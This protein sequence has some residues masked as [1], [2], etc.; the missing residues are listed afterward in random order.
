MKIL[1]INRHDNFPNCHAVICI[2]AGHLNYIEFILVHNI[3]VRVML[4][5]MSV[6]LHLKLFNS[7]FEHIS[8]H[9]KSHLL[10]EQQF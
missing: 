9:V 8:Q 7:E 6:I 10:I 2:H 4:F 5:L 3:S 1:P